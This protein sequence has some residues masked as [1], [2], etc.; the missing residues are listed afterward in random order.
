MTD[1]SLKS[2]KEKALKFPE[3]IKSLILSE[4]DALDSKEFISKVSTW[5][6]IL[7]LSKEVEK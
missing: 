3:P 4:P 5:E 6:K 2:L 7:Q 1:V